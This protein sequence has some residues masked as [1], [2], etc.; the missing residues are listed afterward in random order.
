M[1]TSHVLGTAGPSAAGPDDIGHSEGEGARSQVDLVGLVWGVRAEIGIPDVEGRQ[2]WRP[3]EKI[4]LMVLHPVLPKRRL[5]PGRQWM[6][7]GRSGW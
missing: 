2:S 3:T 6:V 1:S 7:F 4:M 5:R